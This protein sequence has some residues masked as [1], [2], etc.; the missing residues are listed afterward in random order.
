VM[1]STG[2]GKS[3]FVKL[4]TG[5]SSVKIGTALD[6][7]TSSVQ[8]LR[9]LDP[10]SR[11][12]VVVVDT[13]GFDDSRTGF[14]DTQILATITKFLLNEYDGNRKLN[15]LVYLQRISDPRFGGQ[16]SRNL[17]M[18]QSLC[19][20]NNYK[21]VIVLTTFWDR[22]D[23][24]EEGLK[25]EEQLRSRYLKDLLDGGARF[26]RYNQ[27][28]RSAQRVLAHVMTLTPTNVD[29]QREI[30]MEGKSLE[31]TAAGSVHR[32]EVE[33]IIAKHNKEVSELRTE[34]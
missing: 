15:A 16:T 19:G 9:F 6:S 5:N 13:P 8:V 31:D 24:E 12:N 20:A 29:I 10:V 27:T 4:L 25:R 22:V 7:E 26:M 32:E 21:N 34:L 33:R 11:R 3:S 18:F 23:V 14:T 1:G 17:K 30:R 28:I 2:T